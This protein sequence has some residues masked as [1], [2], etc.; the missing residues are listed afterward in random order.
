[1]FELLLSDIYLFV[2]YSQLSSDFVYFADFFFSSSDPKVNVSYLRHNSQMPG[3]M[4]ILTWV[5]I[6]FVKILH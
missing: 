2:I 4:L 5:G 1:M 3:S 6:I